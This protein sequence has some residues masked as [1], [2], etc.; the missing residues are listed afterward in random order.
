[1]QELKIG[2]I[3]LGNMGFAHSSCIFGGNVEH[4]RLGAICDINEHRR[5][6]A[7]EHFKDVPCFADY[8]EMMDSGL[9]DAVLIAVP[10]RLH[11]EI[12]LQALEK[13]LHVL[14]EKP[15]DITISAA[16]RI[17]EAAKASNRV[18]GIMFN[19]R[20]NPLFQKAREIIQNG[21]LGELK[22]SVW[23]ITN[24]YRTQAYYDSGS[25]RAT[26]AGE[27]GG[28]LLNQAPH[29]LD[30]WQWICGMPESVTAFCDVG[31]Y[32][33]I[34][35][36]DDVTIFTRYA[37]GAVGTFITTTGEYPGTNRLEIAGDLGKIVIEN[38]V[39]HWWKLAQ[40]EREYCVTAKSSSCET[41]P[42]YIEIKQDAPEAAHRGILQN[43]T[44]AV[45]FGE[46]LLAPGFDGINE[47][48]LSNAA[49]L[50]SWKGSAEIKLPFDTEEYD[51]LLRERAANSTFH[52]AVETEELSETYVPRWQVSW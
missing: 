3:G 24:W 48:T 23:I 7:S 27:G 47:L 34:E 12:A 22:R 15:I 31:K 32:H 13:G 43:F 35:V 36:E 26:W 11:V 6:Y 2:I 10:H 33:K 41:A 14:V 40:P 51:A 50:S 18:F 42:E 1:M 37:N 44:N 20:T 30:L 9:I 52:D 29:N 39:L 5:K 21:E 16:K 38:G 25:W 49:Y 46:S 17:N 45:L 4:L 19:Q 8:S 28:V